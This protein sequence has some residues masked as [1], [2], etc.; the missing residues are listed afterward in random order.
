MVTLRKRNEDLSTKV[1]PF[2]IDLSTSP[3]RPVGP[4]VAIR[5]GNVAAIAGDVGEKLARR[6]RGLIHGRRRIVLAR[7]DLPQFTGSGALDVLPPIEHV[8]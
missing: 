3:Q 4:Q 7:D 5:F 2:R 1:Q 8:A 6:A